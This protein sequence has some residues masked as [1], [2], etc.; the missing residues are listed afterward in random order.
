MLNFFFSPNGRITRWQFWQGTAAQLVLLGPGLLRL[1]HAAQ[2]TIAIQTLLWAGL[3]GTVL[4]WVGACLS[5]K[6][7]HD[8]GKSAWWSLLMFVPLGQV[9]HFIE[10]GFLRGDPGANAYGP[11]PGGEAVQAAAQARSALDGSGAPGIAAAARTIARITAS[12]P[13]RQ[14]ASVAQKPKANLPPVA[15]SS[16]DFPERKPSLAPI[17]GWRR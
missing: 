5:S 1:L 12:K 4:L 15:A 2:T 10:C 8:R 3:E 6:R 17:F 11:V 7:L 9:W 14:R 16:A 13:P